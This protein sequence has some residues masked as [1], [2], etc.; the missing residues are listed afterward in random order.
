MGLWQ[1]KKGLCIS[2]NFRY[3][4]HEQMLKKVN[5]FQDV[6]STVAA[7]YYSNKNMKRE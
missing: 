7:R 1:R 3:K 6:L 4:T 2:S 5:D